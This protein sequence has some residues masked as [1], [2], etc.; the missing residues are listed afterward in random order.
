VYAGH[1]VE[2]LIL[3]QRRLDRDVRLEVLATSETRS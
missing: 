1:L 2:V 3:V